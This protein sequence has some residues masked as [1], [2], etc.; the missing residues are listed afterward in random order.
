M[1]PETIQDYTWLTSPEAAGLLEESQTAI[2]DR[3]NILTIVKRLRREISPSRAAL[4]TELAQIRLKA[5]KKFAQADQMFFTRK[6]YEQSSGERLAHYKSLAFDG[7]PLV[8]DICCGI[9]GDLLGLG[10]RN[11]NGDTHGFDK[12]LLC[13][14]YAEKNTE[15][16]LIPDVSVALKPFSEVPLERLRRAPYRSGSKEKPNPID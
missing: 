8:A 12:E 16:N 13:A 1:N 7:L 3:I 11:G 6:G 4:V 5:R 15:A 2:L 9:G 14:M 10:S